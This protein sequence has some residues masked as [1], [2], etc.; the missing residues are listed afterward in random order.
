MKFKPN[1]KTGDMELV[2]TNEGSQAKRHQELKPGLLVQAVGGQSVVGFGYKR[3]LAAIKAGDRPLTVGFISQPEA[4]T[5]HDTKG[6]TRVTFTEPGSLGLKFTPNSQTGNVEVLA[7]NPGTQA[8][9]HAALRGGLVLASIA[10]TSVVGTSYQD[11]IGMI[12][13]GGR[14]LTLG[15]VEK[16]AS[17]TPEAA[18]A[19]AGEV[20]VTFTEPGSLGLKFTPNKKTG[21]VE[22]LAVNPGTQAETH[23]ALRGGL[24]L[25]TVA[26]ASCKGKSYQE[27]LGMI[28]AGGRPLAMTF[29]PGGTVS[30]SP[31]S[32]PAAAKAEMTMPTPLALDP[33]PAPAPVVAMPASVVAAAAAAS[34][35]E[36]V[37][38]AQVSEDMTRMQARIRDL[39]SKLDDA[40]SSNEISKLQEQLQAQKA[41]GSE[42]R[43]H[44]AAADERLQAGAAAVQRLRE[45]RREE[46]A[47]TGQ[48]IEELKE[49]VSILTK[50]NLRQEDTLEQQEG[51]LQIFE[52]QLAATEADMEEK[53]EE[54]AAANA[55]IAQ[56]ASQGAGGAGGAEAVELAAAAANSRLSEAAVAAAN[57][58]AENEQLKAQLAQLAAAAEGSPDESQALLAQNQVLLA[59]KDTEL[60]SIVTAK[61]DALAAAAEMHAAEKARADDL[62][63]QLAAAKAV[64]APA[65]GGK[66]PAKKKG[67]GGMC[68]AKPKKH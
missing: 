26:G 68:G 5:Y 11:V 8:E 41:V 49:K 9:K 12:K 29:V 1:T 18:S 25:A 13:A 7:V 64:A 36:S 22:L 10:A 66:R 59:A 30:A 53:D 55:T 32:S 40:E 56:L 57:L 20:R 54:L 4:P 44:A 58:E 35:E 39:M 45:N 62:D 67:G 6:E 33:T 21:N 27:C 15:F 16:P 50:K 14:P 31:S 52:T 51:K 46:V 65:A 2:G 17:V 63:V 28:K 60:Q 24:V 61:D 37:P 43:A 19:P 3:T 34:P 23:S 47:A 38:Q 42:A 48:E